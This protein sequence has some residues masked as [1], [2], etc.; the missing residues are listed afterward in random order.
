MSHGI[1]LFPTVSG[2]AYF[3]ASNENWAAEA[4]ASL[5]ST[6]N[7]ITAQGEL[8]ILASTT[9]AVAVSP[10]VSLLGSL[11]PVRAEVLYKTVD[12]SQ[13]CNLTILDQTDTVL[14]S[15]NFAS[16]AYSTTYN[17]Y[18]R[19]VLDVDVPS[20]TTGVKLRICQGND[21]DGEIRVN[22]AALNESILLLDPDQI[23]R[24]VT[25]VKAT[26]TTLS[27]RR[28][29]DVLQRHYTFEYS[30]NGVDA[31]TYDRIQEHFYRN[32]ALRLDDGDVPDNQEVYPTFAKGFI[33]YATLQSF[34]TDGEVYA[35]SFDHSLL[36][37]D[38]AFSVTG[39]T[40]WGVGE[41]ARVGS[42]TGASIITSSDSMYT[43]ARL[44]IPTVAASIGYWE[45]AVTI[46]VDCVSEVNSTG[47]GHVGFDVWAYDWNSSVWHRVRSLPRSGTYPLVL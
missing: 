36:P 27:G 46:G 1:K 47:A 31:T 33:D 39:V 9:L 16:S 37:S 4:T 42:T 23:S 17:D 26:H 40:S 8:H 24:R 15:T 19:A 43:Y 14:A 29:V 2:R 35:Q 5:Y 11:T 22:E 13:T 30:W 18:K 20:G 34:Y 12:S 10:A 44:S 21:I 28:I 45:S 3:T 38:A 32:E 41:F 25:P 6:P 7:S